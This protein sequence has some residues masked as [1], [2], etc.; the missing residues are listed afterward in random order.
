MLPTGGLRNGY[1]RRRRRSSPRPD[2]S[3]LWAFNH[4]A[5]PGKNR[6]GGQPDDGGH[7]SGRLLHPRRHW[8]ARLYAGQHPTQLPLSRGNPAVR[9]RG[10]G[11][12]P[13]P[14]RPNSHS[15][16]TFLSFNPIGRWTPG[17]SSITD[18]YPLDD[19]PPDL[20]GTPQ[21]MA[22]WMRK[23][24]YEGQLSVARYVLNHALALRVPAAALRG[25]LEQVWQEAKADEHQ[26]AVL[27]ELPSRN[28][29]R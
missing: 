8:G 27:A 3:L 23:K 21:G 15:P 24:V 1:C 17:D 13:D 18:P 2:R 4:L 12:A 19:L 10:V 6:H 28:F 11:S 26:A 9:L 29:L 16:Q 25:W 5:P 14:T 22:F 7:L 20:Q